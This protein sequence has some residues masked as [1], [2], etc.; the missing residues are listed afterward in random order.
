MEAGGRARAGGGGY[1]LPRSVD[2]GGSGHA[3][4]GKVEA[5]AC[6]CIV[7]VYARAS[8]ATSRQWKVRLKVRQCEYNEALR[9]RGP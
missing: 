3:A 8:Y 5:R 2:H 7:R 1:T 9:L 4:Q 6:V